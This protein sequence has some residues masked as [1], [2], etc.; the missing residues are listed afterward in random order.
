MINNVK[1]WREEGYFVEN[2]II[3]ED[4][5]I[6]SKNYIEKLYE[7]NNLNVED[8]GSKGKLE[9]PSN[10][11]ID[12]IMIN[13]NIIKYVEK[14]LNNTEILLV[15]ADAWGKKGNDDYSE[16]SN[17]NQRMHMDYGNNSFLHPSKWEEPESV[18][19]IIYLSDINKTYGGTS[20]VPRMGENDE[21]YKFPYKNMPGI[22]D[23]IFINDKDKA[24]EYFKNK[25]EDIYNFRK[26]LYD[27]EINLKPN[28]GNILFYRTDIWHRGTPVKKGEVRFVINLLWKKKECYWINIWNPGWTRKMYYGFMEELFT[29]MTPLQRSVL[30]VPMPGDDYWDKDKL[31]LLKM[32]YPKI[33]IGIYVKYLKK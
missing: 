12:K 15:Q 23:N 13:E 24:E 18:S 6:E 5:I 33:D 17:N 31:D 25:D 3:S 26:K 27:R 20:I 8:F 16:F 14:L 9:F 4:L 30:G 21:L 29:N 10:T 22:N 7:N 32:R 11:I 1:K 2:N 28:M 19:M